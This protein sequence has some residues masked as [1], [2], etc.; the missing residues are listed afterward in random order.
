MKT[1]GL[2][3]PL[4]YDTAIRKFI[5]VCILKIGF[6][7]IE[8]EGLLEQI[9]IS[10]LLFEDSFVVVLD[11]LLILG[12]F[13]VPGMIEESLTE[14][15]HSLAST[16]L[17]IIRNTRVICILPNIFKWIVCCCYVKH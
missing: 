8:Y 1:F 4:K 15:I 2:M 13:Q 9:S 6:E 16:T 3:L 17:N 7:M 10:Q 14:M 5:E 11:S 12:I